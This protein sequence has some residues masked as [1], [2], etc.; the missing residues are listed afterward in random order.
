[1]YKYINILIYKYKYIFIDYIYIFRA[2]LIFHFFKSHQNCTQFVS[3]F[4]FNGRGTSQT[5]LKSTKNNFLD[6]SKI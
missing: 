3:E 4:F 5:T 2:K 1:M 6:I